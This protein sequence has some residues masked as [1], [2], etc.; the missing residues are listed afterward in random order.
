MCGWFH[1]M[2]AD[3]PPRFGPA[4]VRVRGCRRSLLVGPVDPVGQVGHEPTGPVRVMEVPLMPCPSC[5]HRRTVGGSSCRGHGEVGADCIPRSRPE[6]P[7]GPRPK[8]HVVAV[9]YHERSFRPS[10]SNGTR[11]KR[12]RANVSSPITS[13]GSEI[14]FTQ[15]QKSIKDHGAGIRVT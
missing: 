12:G 11:C 6:G 5:T 14:P 3:Q 13:R 7:P 2:H 15:E 4:L 10:T 1:H 9:H 8:L